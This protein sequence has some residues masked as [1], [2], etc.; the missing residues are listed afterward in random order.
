MNIFLK[1]YVGENFKKSGKALDLGA[2]NFFNVNR[3]KK[4]GWDC[5]GVDLKT[6]VDLNNF[7]ISD[8]KPFD[9]IYSTFVLHF[10]KNKEKFI[11]TIY[12]NLK[13]GGNF[14]ILA[15]HKFDKICDSD[16]TKTSLKK[17]LASQGFKSV[18]IKL[19]S[20]YDNGIGH[21]HWHKIL[22]AIGKK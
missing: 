14:Y 9:L 22:E 20:H 3:L 15:M 7:F 11:N 17:L 8:N 13:D 4:A 18:K 1:E 16:L 19:L 10:I 6:G 21:K 5:D 12:H 2:G